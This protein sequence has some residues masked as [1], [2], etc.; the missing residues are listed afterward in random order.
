MT[1]Y[2]RDLARSASRVDPVTACG[3]VCGR[4]RLVTNTVRT[5]GLFVAFAVVGLVLVWI[6][7]AQAD[8]ASRLLHME[9][10]RIA[11][12]RELWEIE[13]RTARLRAPAR[14]IEAAEL[15]PA[16]LSRPGRDKPLR[17]PA[18][19]IVKRH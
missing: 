19:T 10:Q 5:V 18:T 16:D 2:P 15:S 3:R 9:A 7:S 13:T 11:L 14:I 1:D 8:A 12:R 6:R 17:G 4:S